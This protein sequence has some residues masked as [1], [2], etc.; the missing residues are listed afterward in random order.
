MKTV[1]RYSSR[2]FPP[3]RHLPGVTP[4]PERSPDG[5][6]AGEPPWPEKLDAPGSRAYRE[7]FL[8]GVDLFNHAY[9]WEAHAAWERLWK[10]AP[11]DP[12]QAAFLKGLIQAT[13]ALVKWRA[14]KRG[15][16]A[17]LGEKSLAKLGP[18]AAQ[19]QSHYLG[20]NLSRFT[21]ELARFL[22]GASSEPPLL[23][24]EDSR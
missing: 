9:W 4:H 22:A 18:L 3:Y 19:G 20:V 15:G 8:Y 21:A 5:H 11:S 12:N 7:L 1:P 14:G 13:A 2:A 10:E 16:T 6:T 24:L 23:W 17:R